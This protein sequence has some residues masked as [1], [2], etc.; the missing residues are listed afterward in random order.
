MD[1]AAFDEQGFGARGGGPAE[2][3]RGKDQTLF[4]AAHQCTSLQL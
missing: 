2:Q 4:R 1:R 3:R